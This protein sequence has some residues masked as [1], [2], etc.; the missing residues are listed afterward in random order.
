VLFNTLKEGIMKKG[1]FNSVKEFERAVKRLADYFRGI[2]G[3]SFDTA[4]RNLG[5]TKEQA[6]ILA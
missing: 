4:C 6:Q 3:I 1:L 2:S 5:Y